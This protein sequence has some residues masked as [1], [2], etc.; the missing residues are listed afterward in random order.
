MI[1]NNQILR[2]YPRTSKNDWSSLYAVTKTPMTW[3]AQFL[4]MFLWIILL[5]ILFDEMK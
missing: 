5:F 2:N 4:L 1:E 3:W